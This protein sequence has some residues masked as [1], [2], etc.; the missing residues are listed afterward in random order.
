VPSSKHRVMLF[1]CILLLLGSGCCPFSVTA[2]SDPQAHNGKWCPQPE[3][4][5]FYLPKPLLVISQNF[6]YIEES[7]LGLTDPVPIPNSFGNQADYA[8]LQATAGINT[9]GAATTYVPTGPTQAGQPASADA[10]CCPH[11][12]PHSSKE[13]GIPTAPN[14]S[15]SSVPFFTYQIIFVPDLTQK[16]YLRI[17][18]GPG[19]VRAALNLVNGWMYTGLG[20]FYM[21]DSSTAQNIL[22][23]GV[24]LKFAGS[25]AAD[26]INSVNNLSKTLR[27]TPTSTNVTALLGALKDT[28]QAA[29]KADTPPP[30]SCITA[31]IHV[32][33]PH[34]T[35]D[36][37]MVWRKINCDNEHFTGMV[38]GTD[39][40]GAAKRADLLNGFKNVVDSAGFQ[41]AIALDSVNAT[42]AQVSPAQAFQQA[43]DPAP[44]L[45]VL[46]APLPQT[47]KRLWDCLFP[48]SKLANKVVN[49]PTV[50][51]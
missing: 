40:K 18:G 43:F 1:L 48:H 13:T 14:V 50:A 10:A 23:S 4:L 51:Q 25:G 24:L 35:P 44:D 12:V 30:N 3:G 21:K 39:P 31:E 27:T 33:E 16:H 47:R 32:Y 42:G 7:H 34:L 26:V 15:S 28:L 38:L 2:I 41:K 49:G 29:A 45:A 46:Q 22:A 6:Q 8:S 5:P 36:G 37:D 19:E 11:Q 17:K 9:A 20:P